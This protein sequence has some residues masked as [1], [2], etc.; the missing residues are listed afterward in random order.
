MRRELFMALI[1]AWYH[2]SIELKRNVM[3]NFSF[4]FSK[5]MTPDFLMSPQ[6]VPL[7]CT[8][9]LSFSFFAICNTQVYSKKNVC[10]DNIILSIWSTRKIL[11][12]YY[13]PANSN[14]E[15]LS[16]ACTMVMHNWG[17]KNSC[18]KKFLQLVIPWQSS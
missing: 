13:N 16:K 9:F 14:T 15:Y 12:T 10:A 6:K 3:C 17:V 2:D 7:F 1:S 18:L 5:G 4:M 11:E 8:I